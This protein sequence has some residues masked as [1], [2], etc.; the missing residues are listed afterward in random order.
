M[1]D[2]ATARDCARHSR[3]LVVS[4]MLFRL[5]R[6]AGRR[7]PRDVSSN[8]EVSVVDIS[9]IAIHSR[10][11]AEPSYALASRSKAKLKCG[12]R[13]DREDAAVAERVN[14]LRSDL[15]GHVFA[16]FTDWKRETNTAADSA[17]QRSCDLPRLDG[18]RSRSSG[19]GDG[20]VDLTV[21]FGSAQHREPDRKS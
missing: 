14:E 7:L 17:E 20:H 15:C 1:S 12:F 8:S 16:A 2:D 9:T 21:V 6:S 10:K 4:Q 13:L 11:Q 19:F 5:V 3:K 18:L